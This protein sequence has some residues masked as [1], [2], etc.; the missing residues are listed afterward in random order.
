LVIFGK[1][2][3]DHVSINVSGQ[4]AEGWSR[5]EFVV[6]TG[7]FRGGCDASFYQG[8]LR[9]FASEIEKLHRDLVGFAELQPI[10]PFLELKL[11][12]DGRGHIFVKGKAQNSLSDET[13]LVFRFELDQTE[14]PA[15]VTALRAA[16]PE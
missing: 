11:A 7:P 15:I 1:L 10:E 13:Y 9:Q 2:S 8:E 14:L 12:G 16:N 3:S 6:R 4:D 5:A